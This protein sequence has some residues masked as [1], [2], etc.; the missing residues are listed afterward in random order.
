MVVEPNDTSARTSNLQQTNT[1]GYKFQGSKEQF[2]IAERLVNSWGP[3]GVKYSHTGQC[4]TRVQELMSKFPYRLDTNFAKTDRIV[5]AEI[6][7]FKKRVL[8][9]TLHGM[10]IQEWA[11]LLSSDDEAKIEKALRECV[12]IEWEKTLVEEPSKNGKELSLELGELSGHGSQ[13]RHLTRHFGKPAHT[14]LEVGRVNLCAVRAA[15]QSA[16]SQRSREKAT[17]RLPDHVADVGACLVDAGHEIKW[18][19]IEVHGAT[20]FG[21]YAL[22]ASDSVSLPYVGHSV[23]AGELRTHALPFAAGDRRLAIQ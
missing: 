18:L 7:A 6:E 19:L 4:Q 13:K 21:L 2:V 23:W 3:A 1:N 8:S 22:F 16:G 5:H 10:T 9:S 12:K 11:R 20:V 14:V 15:L 17:E